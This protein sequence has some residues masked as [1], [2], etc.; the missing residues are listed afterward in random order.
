MVRWRWRW[1]AVPR[2]VA[3]AMLLVGSANLNL[4]VAALVRGTGSGR[5]S[6]PDMA[7]MWQA[8]GGAADVGTFSF[9]STT[10]VHVFLL[11]HWVPISMLG[12]TILS[13]L[14]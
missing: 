10:D 2:M 11:R 14:E 1:V 3:F 4:L 8:L 6:P 12:Q 5:W 7:W 9:S 13:L